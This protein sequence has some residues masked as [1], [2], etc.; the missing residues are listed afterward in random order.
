MKKQE[1]KQTGRRN[2]LR[3]SAVAGAGAA[4]VASTPASALA[5]TET[6]QAEEKSKGYRVTEHV[7]AYY[8]TAAE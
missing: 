5:L 6:E 8:K 3:S 1:L 2:F 7:S 4:I